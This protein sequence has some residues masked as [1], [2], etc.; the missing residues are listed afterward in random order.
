[1]VKEIRDDENKLKYEVKETPDEL[2]KR[3]FDKKIQLK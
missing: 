3:F 2:Y 1:M